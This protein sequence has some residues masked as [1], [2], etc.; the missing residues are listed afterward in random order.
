MCRLPVYLELCRADFTYP[1][2]CMQKSINLLY[3]S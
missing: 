2:N 3:Q 1:T